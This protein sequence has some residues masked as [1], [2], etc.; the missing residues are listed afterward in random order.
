MNVKLVASADGCRDFSSVSQTKR[1][2]SSSCASQ[3]CWGLP[4]SAYTGPATLRCWVPGLIGALRRKPHLRTGDMAKQCEINMEESRAMRPAFSISPCGG[5]GKRCLNSPLARDTACTEA[6]SQECRLDSFSLV[7]SRL[8]FLR[9][10]AASIGYKSGLNGLRPQT[11]LLALPVWP[12][13]QR[14]PARAS[15]AR[16]ARV[17]SICVRRLRKGILRFLSHSGMKI[18]WGWLSNPSR[19]QSTPEAHKISEGARF[20]LVRQRQTYHTRP[21][22]SA[23]F[24][25]NRARLKAPA[26]DSES[27]YLK[28]WRAFQ[29][30][31]PYRLQRRERTLL[32]A[33]LQLRA[34]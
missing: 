11:T 12:Q 30:I 15:Q 27:V 24:P 22:P 2:G 20:G 25:K 18:A 9:V 4:N 21:V 8:P 16:L 28:G 10:G 14:V 1:F 6:K 23:A 3:S 7:G 31:R 19:T 32:L 33:I 34:Q 13:L 26:I 5:A 17:W 29:A